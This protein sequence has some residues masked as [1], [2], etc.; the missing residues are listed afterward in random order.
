MTLWFLIFFLLL[1]PSGRG[2]QEAPSEPSLVSLLEKAKENTFF[3]TVESGDTLGKLAKKYGT[4]VELLKRT[5]RLSGDRIYPDMKLK[6]FRARFSVRV[7]KRRNRLILLANG[8]PIHRYQVATGEKGSTP[9]GVFKIVNK[10]KNPTWFHTGLVLPPT[11]PANILGSRWLGFDLSGYGIHGTTLPQTIGTQA[12]N[13]CI[14]MLN[15]EVEALYDLLP[16][17]T[18]VVVSD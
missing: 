4:T 8:K 7:E 3:H 18:R 16:T 9:V 2:Q 10:L 5:N 12:S 13:G 1:T 15:A 17:G 6:V 14:R 11:S